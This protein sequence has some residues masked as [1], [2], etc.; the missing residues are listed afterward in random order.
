[1]RIKRKHVAQIPIGSGLQQGWILRISAHGPG[2][3]GEGEGTA[4]TWIVN[5]RQ[6]DT[7]E[8]ANL[9]YAMSPGDVLSHLADFLGIDE[10]ERRWDI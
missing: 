6:A 9:A 4:P 1:M 2:E 8:G 10:E 7:T 3:T 5:W